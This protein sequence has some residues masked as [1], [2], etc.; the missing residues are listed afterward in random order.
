[1]INQ[2]AWAFILISSFSTLAAC[3]GEQDPAVKGAA[4]FNSYGCVKCHAIGE[5]GGSYGPNLTLIGFRKTPQWLDLWLKNPHAWRS[6]TV[7]PNFH[8]S[9][10]M[11]GDLVAY[12]SQQKGQAWETT[13]RPWN[14]PALAADPV[15]RGEVLF[16]KAGCVACHSQN[17]RGGYSNNNVVGNQIPALTKVYETYTKAELI[18]KIRGGVAPTPADPSRPAPMI[19]MPKWGEFLK[20]D[21]ISAVADFL[22]SFKP[23]GSAAKKDAW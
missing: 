10:E 14:D 18:N 19:Q 2:R 15:K 9:D 22:I 5:T 4:Y 17:G 20:D 12:L 21:E 7:M 8:L 6:Q 3:R 23:T 1:M 16:N 13:G 11:R